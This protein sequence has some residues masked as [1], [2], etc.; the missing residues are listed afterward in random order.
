MSDVT[1]DPRVTVCESRA[2][3]GPVSELLEPRRVQ[4]GESTEVRRLLPSLGRRMVGAWCFVDHYGPD[5]IAA[6]PGMQVA[7]HPHIGLQTVSWLLDGEVHHRDSVGSDVL[8]RPGELGLMTAGRGIAHSE[9]SPDRHSPLLHGAQ[10]WVALPGEE[11]RVA[12]RFEHHVDLPQ[13]TTR[14]L[15]ATVLLGELGEARSPGRVHSPIVG[16]DVR[17]SAG[18]ATA[19]PLE[20]DFEHA[21]LTV[22]GAP[23]VDG[24]VVGP[25]TLLYLGTGRREIP[26]RAGPESRFLLLGGEPFAEQ[27]VMWWNFVGRS[28]DEVAEARSLWQAE[29]AGGADHRFGA[30]P[31]YEGLP[32][33]APELPP[34]PLKPRGR[35]R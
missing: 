4:L 14:G 5:E 11:R 3:G 15:R 35:E 31:G 30:V 23:E 26:L 25:G 10:L 19:L 34:T 33:A 21:V 2:T 18:T 1:A 28:G 20:P 7:P 29:I 17:L 6:E 13:V 9:Q 27:L 24:R 16:V 8:V 32:L 22:S 12:P